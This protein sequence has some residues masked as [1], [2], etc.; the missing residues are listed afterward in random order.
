MQ[1]NLQFQFRSA[2]ER[3]D[4]P[5]LS[6]HF[7]WY[8]FRV[9]INF[10]AAE[11]S[12]KVQFVMLAATMCP[13]SSRAFLRLSRR[14]RLAFYTSYNAA[15]CALGYYAN[16][17]SNKQILF[18]VPVGP[19]SRRFTCTPNAKSNHNRRQRSI[20]S[21]RDQIHL[22]KRCQVRV[23]LIPIVDWPADNAVHA[24]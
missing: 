2:P 13:G 10:C 19:V 3:N 14:I 11:T 12:I 5:R 9:G 6:V 22:E 8:F 21:T 1:I 15:A 16:L 4:F 18:P 7:R 23:P 24:R 17:N 20:L